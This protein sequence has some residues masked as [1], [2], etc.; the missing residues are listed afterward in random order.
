MFLSQSNVKNL[1]LIVFWYTSNILVVL[2]NKFLLS[3]YG[4]K[5][6]VFLTG[7]HMLACALLGYGVSFLNLTPR[8]TIQS[9]WQLLKVTLL[10]FVFCITVVLGNISLR[11]IPVSFNQ[12]I[13]ATTPFFT[14]FMS[15]S[16]LRSKESVIV[17]ISLAPVV[18]GI[19][20]A[21]GGEPLFNL[22]GFLAALSATG[23]RAFKSVL[24]G[25]LLTDTSEKMNS[26]N[27][28]L[29]MAP[30]ATLLLVPA[31]VLAEP[32]VLEVVRE[33]AAKDRRFL[34][35][36]VVNATLAFFVNLSNFIMTKQTSALTL[37]VLGNAKGVVAAGISILIFK[38]PVT[39]Q[40]AVGYAIALFG[41]ALYSHA[42]GTS[43][44]LD[45]KSSAEG[46]Q[47]G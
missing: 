5:F 46:H 2:S 16:I 17:Y 22:V 1:T 9:K 34:P 8:Q 28:L 43:Q 41:V 47:G 33:K 10:A 6:P 19:M 18:I 14:A 12:V 30:I 4:F 32:G 27:L 24:Q 23:G 15:Y 7:C 42:K 37:Q 35:A 11:F 36:L 21:T 13:G 20:I 39:M 3:N 45:S 38:N 31:V 26:M 44:P 40:G 29:Y 25:L